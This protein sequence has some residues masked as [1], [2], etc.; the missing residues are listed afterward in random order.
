MP[1]PPPFVSSPPF[2]PGLQPLPA[3]W[4]ALTAWICLSVPSPTTTTRCW[5]SS[6]WWLWPLWRL[7]TAPWPPT[8]RTP[9][10]R[11]TSTPLPTVPMLTLPTLSPIIRLSA[12]RARSLTWSSPSFC[13]SSCASSAWSTPVASSPVTAALRR[14]S[15][16]LMPLWVWP[17]VPSS[18][19][20]SRSSGTWS[21]RS[22]PSVRW[23]IWSP[24]ASRP[25]SP[26][27][28]S[29]PSPGPWSPWLTP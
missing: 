12:P 6:W 27:S 25:W 20:S 8:K 14:L 2:L 4:M 29:W 17:M 13:W 24:K 22:W 9:S 7:N 10:K 1:L 23:W 16:I 3:L 18:L 19:W 26:P 11:A 15:P 28:W 21:A 5:P